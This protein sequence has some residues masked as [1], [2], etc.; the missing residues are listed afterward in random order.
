VNI[1]KVQR[2]AVFAATAG[3]RLYRGRCACLGQ[4]GEHVRLRVLYSAPWTNT[5]IALT[6]MFLFQ[7]SAFRLQPLSF[8]F[9]FPPSALFRVNPTLIR[10]TSESDPTLIPPPSGLDPALNKP[11]PTQSG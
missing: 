5:F 6:L 1:K 11:Y 9:R 4:L 2:A 3:S 7:V 8:D 10:P